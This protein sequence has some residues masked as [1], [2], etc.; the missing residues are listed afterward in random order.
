MKRHRR[1]LFFKA[2]KQVAKV[3]YT[4]VYFLCFIAALMPHEVAGAIPIPISV[5]AY[6]Y[7]HS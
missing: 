4:K 3:K 5:T 7:L 6:L 2:P 1:D